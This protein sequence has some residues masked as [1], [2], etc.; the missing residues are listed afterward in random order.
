[1]GATTALR[2][3]A[4]DQHVL[5]AVS[6]ATGY[7]RPAVVEGLAAK[8]F[9]LR[10]EYVDGLSLPDLAAQSEPL[11]E[12]A[13]PKLAGRPVLYVAAER[14]MLVSRRSVDELYERAPEPKQLVT[15]AS[16]H[17]YAGEN[18]RAAVVAWL[19]ERHAR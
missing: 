11:L 17:T 5:G 19:N 9:D 12:A 15:V 13:L 16:D 3:A 18:S 6:I 8:S 14:D 10:A 1:M 7:G 4:A 2:A